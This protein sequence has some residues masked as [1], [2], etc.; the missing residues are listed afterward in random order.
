MVL[1][2]D[3]VYEE[4]LDFLM[5]YTRKPDIDTREDRNAIGLNTIIGGVYTYTNGEGELMESS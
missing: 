3:A 1:G 4:T 2:L 5:T